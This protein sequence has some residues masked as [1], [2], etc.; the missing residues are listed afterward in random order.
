MECELS[1]YGLRIQNVR[2]SHKVGATYTVAA[3]FKAVVTYTMI[4]MI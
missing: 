2:V 4:I 1:V 3:R